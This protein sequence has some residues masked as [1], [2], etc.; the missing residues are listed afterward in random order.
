MK[1]ILCYGDSNTWGYNPAAQ[2]RYG[3]D[4]RWTGVLRNAL[5]PGYLII[6]E[7]L[8]GRTTVWDDPV[9]GAH[10]NGKW[11]LVPCLETHR[12]LDLVVLMLG[13]NDLK[14]R[15]AVS[16]RDIA[17]SVG[18]LLQVIRQ[19]GA[20][21]DDGPPAALLVAPPPVARLSDF[22]GMFEGA[23]PKSRRLAQYYRLS[24]EHRGASFLDAGELIV[25]SDLDGV[26]LD[27]DEHRKLGEAIAGRVREICPA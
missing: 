26:H 18:E 13:T 16:A 8:N 19:S 5:G 11:Y 25:S 21:P 23:G 4:E 3:R 10:K 22:A 14:A 12:P 27:L 7:G 6:E 24:A 15:F 20:G 2:A 1:T 9:E 17:A